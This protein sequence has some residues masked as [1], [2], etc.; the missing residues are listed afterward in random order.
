MKATMKTLETDLI[1]Y[2]GALIPPEQLPA[3]DYNIPLELSIEF[4]YR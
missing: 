4:C 3:W 1:Y 2:K